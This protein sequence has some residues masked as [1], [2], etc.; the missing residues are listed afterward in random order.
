MDSKSMQSWKKRSRYCSTK[1]PKKTDE[2]MKKM[3]SWAKKEED[4]SDK[5]LP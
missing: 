2:S 1:K 5:E 3:L 4:N